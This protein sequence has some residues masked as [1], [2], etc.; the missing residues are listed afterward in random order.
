MSVSAAVHTAFAAV[1]L[2]FGFFA[3]WSLASIPLTL[4][5]RPFSWLWLAFATGILGA[6]LAWRML[7]GTLAPLLL[8]SA[9]IPWDIHLPRGGSA[10]LWAGGLIAFA[11]AALAFVPTSNALPL[12]G[13]TILLAVAA[14]L[15][16]DVTASMQ[17]TMPSRAGAAWAGLGLLSF[18]IVALYLVILRPD[19]DDAFYLNLPI[20]LLSEQTCMMAFDTMYGAENWPLL[21][22]NYRVETLP[23]LTA[24]LSWLTGLSVITVSHLV[25]PVIWCVIWACLL[26][27][28]GHGMF[29]RHWLVFAVFWVLASMALAGTLQTWGVHGIARLFHGKAPLILIVIPLMAYLVA[30]VSMM[31]SKLTPTLAALFGLCTVAVGLTA[32][33]IYLAPLVIFLSVMAAM[34]AWPGGKGLRLVLLLSAATPL[35]AGLWLL[36]FDRPVDAGGDAVAGVS[37][38]LALWNMA[39]HKLTLGVV[40]VTLAVAASAGRTGAAGRWVSAY[41]VLFLIFV[42]N[43]VLWPLY[44]RFV[45][46]GLTFRLWWVLPLPTFLAAALTLALLRSGRPV[47]GGALVAGALVLMALLP[48]GL[49]GMEGTRLKAS[50]HKIPPVVDVA[51]Q[52]IH[53]TAPR[54]GTVLAPEEIAAW[55]AVREGHPSLVYTRRLYLTQSAPVVP[56]ERV[57][58]R[59]LLA[60]W[61]NNAVKVPTDDFLAALRALNV[62]LIVLAADDGPANAEYLLRAVGA[63][64]TETASGY[65]LW[66]LPDEFNDMEKRGHEE[67]E[68]I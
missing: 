1:L 33:A 43:P 57:A 9:D 13:V 50:I 27:V 37:T 60:D 39:S 40:V 66:H 38:T 31:P 3:G 42:V 20:G 17:P 10:W 45:T 47:T 56:L 44:D 7:R 52:E 23:T 5:C 58:P 34:I 64:Q 49:I 35:S 36:S 28:I 59:M 21:G 48:S 22:S 16:Q 68:E 54:D 26:A 46:G 19:A 67:A 61:I 12:W 65:M 32:N 63:R 14:I 55:L 15:T 8:R 62:R 53:A 25:L 18:G 29:G 51:V 41:L 6:L 11:L 24:A 2:W 30:R 4:T